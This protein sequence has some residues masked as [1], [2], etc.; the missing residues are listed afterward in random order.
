[1]SLSRPP[2]GVSPQPGLFGIDYQS[3]EHAVVFYLNEEFLVHVLCEC[4]AGSL[5]AGNGV[6]IL[7]TDSH[8][9][10]LADKL[11]PRGID[12]DGLKKQGVLVAI[13]AS[14]VCTKCL[15][16]HDLDLSQLHSFVSPAISWASRTTQ[17]TGARV[18]VYGELVALLWARR[19][20]EAVL[21]VEKFWER[22]MQRLPFWL[23][24]GYPISEF[25]TPGTEDAF[26]R[27]CGTHSIQIPPDG[28]STT[29][30]ERRLLQAAACLDSNPA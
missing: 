12:V 17:P 13:D 14:E 3:S 27:I 16:N 26:A 10:A 22:L 29:E 18:T 28:H 6:V 24:C 20:F 25:D 21:A 8:Q 4:V 1:M 5:K 2:F 30:T 19:E 7:A 23:L 11:R 9:R 15:V